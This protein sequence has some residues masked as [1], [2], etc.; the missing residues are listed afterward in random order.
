MFPSANII[1][2]NG[3]TWWFL[4]CFLL[5]TNSLKYFQWDLGWFGFFFFFIWGIS[6]WNTRRQTHS[7]LWT[8]LIHLYIAGFSPS[9]QF[10]VTLWDSLDFLAC[11]CSETPKTVCI[12]LPL[13]LV[14]I[15]NSTFCFVVLM[16]LCLD[17]WERQQI[18]QLYLESRSPACEF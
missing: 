4:I 13:D 5:G 18:S 17:A 15:W 3:N 12:W 11:H 1:L 14:Y 7:K 9:S 10:A 6:G 8:S 2:Y 16:Y